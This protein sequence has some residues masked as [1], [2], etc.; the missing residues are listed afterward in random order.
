MWVLRQAWKMTDMQ[1]ETIEKERRTVSEINIH[2]SHVS[3]TNLVDTSAIK[4]L[5]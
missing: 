2:S 3:G 5:F 4:I 1:E